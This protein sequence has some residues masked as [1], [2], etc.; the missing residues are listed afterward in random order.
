MNPPE[1]G[2]LLASGD[3][4]MYLTVPFVLSWSMMDALSCAAVVLASSTP[5][6]KEMIRDGENGLLA[7]FFDTDEMADKAVKVLE[8]PGAY[9]PLGRAAEE[10]ITRDYSLEAVLPRMLKMY[11]EA[12]NR[13]AALPKVVKKRAASAAVPPPAPVTR[14]QAK[15]PPTPFLR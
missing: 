4:H 14:E 2:K 1:L 5:P 9:R 12:V 8:D 15:S 11:E 10:I 6:V 13:R 3:L 7:D